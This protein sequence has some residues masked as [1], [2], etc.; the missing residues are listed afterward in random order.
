MLAAWVLFTCRI[1]DDVKKKGKTSDFRDFEE[2][3][4]HRDM[5]FISG[6]CPGS[7][8]TVGSSVVLSG[9]LVFLVDKLFQNYL[10]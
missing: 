6:T 9:F 7:S 5:L 10:D 2:T 3:S 1:T 8:G 4:V